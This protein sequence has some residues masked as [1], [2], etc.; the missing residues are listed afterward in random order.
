MEIITAPGE[1]IRM[2]DGA[3]KVC[4]STTAGAWSERHDTAG[5][6]RLSVETPRFSILSILVPIS[7]SALPTSLIGSSRHERRPARGHTIRS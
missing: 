1:C 5:A 2:K 3:E 7:Q 4:L 6:V